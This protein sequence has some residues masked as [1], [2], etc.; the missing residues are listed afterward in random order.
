VTLRLRSEGEPHRLCER[1]DASQHA[2][3]GIATEPNSLAA[4]G[5]P[6]PQVADLTV[7]RGLI[8]AGGTSSM[9]EQ[10]APTFRLR[11]ARSP[12]DLRFTAIRC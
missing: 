4:F 2:L 6:L 9:I 5:L 7:S 8:L 3:A 11:I 12:R 1:A 10:S